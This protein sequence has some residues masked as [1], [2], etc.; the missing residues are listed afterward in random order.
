MIP[1]I[2]PSLDFD[3]YAD[4]LRSILESGQLTGGRFVAEFELAIARYV[5]CKHAIATTSATTAM[6]MTLAAIGIGPGDEVL[7]SDFTFPATGN[8][9]VQLGATPVLVD[10]A[11]GRFD[12]DIEDLAAKVTPRSRAVLVVHPFGQPADMAGIEAI[13]ARHGLAV[14]ED[15]ACALGAKLPDGR[16]CGSA[17]LAGCFSFH[18]RKLLTTGEGGM[19]TTDDAGLNAKLQVLRSHGGQRAD[20]GLEFIQNGFN[21]RMSEIQAC[22]GLGQLESF[23]AVLEDRRR[24]AREYVE[25]L[26]TLES[27]SVPLSGPVGACTFQSFVVLL[28]DGI[29]RNAVSR[30]MRERGVETTLGTYAMHRHPAFRRFGYLPGD[31]PNADQLERQTLTLPLTRDM[32]TSDVD[33]VVQTL[34]AAIRS[35]G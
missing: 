29:D 9:V 35:H 4:D 7:V 23:D 11:P 22:L 5:G 19:I 31:L 1:L 10:C 8:V 32:P 34:T 30:T 6:H 26:A 25:R 24:T 27:V 16:A 15:A 13:A 14:I 18:P 12:M 20:V 33:R 21:Y 3:R 2:K 28:A 17:S